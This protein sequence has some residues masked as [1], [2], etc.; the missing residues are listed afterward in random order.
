MNPCAFNGPK[1]RKKYNK[2]GEIGGQ[3]TPAKQAAQQ[4]KRHARSESPDHTF[5]V[6]HLDRFAS[7]DHTTPR[8]HNTNAR[9]PLG[10]QGKS[11]IADRPQV[12]AVCIVA[13]VLTNGR[14]GKAGMVVRTPL[15]CLLLLSSLFVGLF[16]KK[17]WT[18]RPRS[19]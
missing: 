17:C 10:V 11:K 15:F 13:I 9:E 3:T 4:R 1:T 6:S 19:A 18:E 8:K 16:L 12:F 14:E 5:R 2:K 7:A